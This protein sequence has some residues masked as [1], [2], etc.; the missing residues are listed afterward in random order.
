MKNSMCNIPG[1]SLH[2]IEERMKPSASTMRFKNPKLETK[3]KTIPSMRLLNA[4]RK[5]GGEEYEE[6]DEETKECPLE[7]FS[8]RESGRA[9]DDVTMIK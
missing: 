4:N 2:K 9:L 3:L 5:G 6:D 7:R 1:D 8:G